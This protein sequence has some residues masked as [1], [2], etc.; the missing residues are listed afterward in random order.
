MTMPSVSQIAED[1]RQ[2]FVATLTLAFANDPFMRWLL[3]D[4][5]DYLTK[6]PGFLEIEGLSLS[7]QH[8]S[9]F[10]TDG[11]EGVSFW[12]PP[13]I[14]GD[15]DV[16][17]QWMSDNVR[18]EILPTLMELGAR[19][20]AAH[21][22]CGPCWYLAYLGVDGA[23]QGQGLGSVLLKDKVEQLDREQQTA[24]LESSNPAN[25]SLYERHGFERI[26]EVAL[27]NAPIITPMVREPRS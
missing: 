25:I 22:S 3:P 6:F 4:S 7:F 2:E 1:K 23:F 15:E 18:P 27:P 14:H 24:Y 26:E 16:M 11:F 19:I 10:A 9:T 13:N 8:N 20:E 12:L 5:A 17:V 21:E